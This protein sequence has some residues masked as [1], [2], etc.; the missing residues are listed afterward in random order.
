MLSVGSGGS[1]IKKTKIAEK[2]APA[3]F[4]IPVHDTY[5]YPLSA[6]R[7]EALKYCQDNYPN[8]QLPVPTATDDWLT[9]SGRT[10]VYNRLNNSV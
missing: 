6:S 9:L 8:G 2:K 10:L 1:L 3:L 5:G 4:T 7:A